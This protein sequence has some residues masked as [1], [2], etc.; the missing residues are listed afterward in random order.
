[1]QN[2]IDW[3][4]IKDISEGFYY[5]SNIPTC[6]KL[7]MLKE[8]A[9]IEINGCQVEKVSVQKKNINWNG[10]Y[11]ELEACIPTAK[12]WEES[13]PALYMDEI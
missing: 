13:K 5:D 1:M 11:F 8:K 2:D 12:S 10:E 4:V 6:K 3:Q 7:L 9:N